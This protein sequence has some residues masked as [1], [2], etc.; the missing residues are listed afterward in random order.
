MEI[1]APKKCVPTSQFICHLCNT[2]FKA[3]FALKQHLLRIHND[4]QHLSNM[5][6]ICT[7]CDINY[8]KENLFKKHLKSYVHLQRMKQ[9]SVPTILKDFDGSDRKPV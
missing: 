4:S 9:F 8:Q 5:A 6:F 7:H 3:K 1:F 2:S